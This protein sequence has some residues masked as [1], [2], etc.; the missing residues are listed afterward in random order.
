MPSRRSGASRDLP[1]LG[2]RART[3]RPGSFVAK[4]AL[5]VNRTPVDSYSRLA[6]GDRAVVGCRL[7]P[8]RRVPRTGSREQPVPELSSG[9]DSPLST[10]PLG[11]LCS[12]TRGRATGASEANRRHR[13]SGL[14]P[15]GLPVVL[16][17]RVA[18]KVS[19]VAVGPELSFGVFSL[20]KDA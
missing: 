13:V 8:S 17:G 12:S 4:A 15:S 3:R 10:S 9:L 6:R 20:A 14:S 2:L 11:E 16:H 7:A 1:E 18:I 5:V 19:T